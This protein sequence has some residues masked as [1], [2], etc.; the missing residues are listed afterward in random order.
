[1]EP[2]DEPL[3]AAES[4][5]TTASQSA[6][7]VP[8]TPP[9]TE[10]AIEPEADSDT[11]PVM[12]AEPAPAAPLESAAVPPTVE[13][14]PD[15]VIT[16]TVTIPA[17]E[18]STDEGG[19]WDLLVE[20]IKAWIDSNQLGSLW[21]QAQ[22]PLRLIGGL[23]LFV[24]V[25]TVYSGILGTINKVPLAPGLLELTG[26]IWL[27]NYA[28]CNLVRSSDRKRVIDALG[29]TWNKVVGR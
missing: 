21:E 11:D 19:E 8:P 9:A 16:S 7:P 2:T 23:I 27:L 3:Q 13:T 5:D 26:V 15:P 17:Q 25:S 4:A 18:A 29:S 20:K 22:L 1:M 10:P 24:I 6:V 12:E 14:T 28:R